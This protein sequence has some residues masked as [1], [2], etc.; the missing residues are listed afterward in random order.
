MSRMDAALKA[1]AH[2]S[3]FIVL[4]LL[5]SNFNCGAAEDLMGQWRDISTL[6]KLEYNWMLL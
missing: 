3:A 5:M 1:A 4:I 2:H 6:E